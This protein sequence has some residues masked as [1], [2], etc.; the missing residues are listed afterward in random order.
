M[1][2]AY[3]QLG[4]RFPSLDEQ[5]SLLMPLRP[6]D[7]A[8]EEPPTIADLPRACQRL[9]SLGAG[10][11]LCIT[12]LNALGGTAREVMAVFAELFRRGVIVETF[13]ESGELYELGA[14]RQELRLLD[15]LVKRP[16]GPIAEASGRGGVVRP[17]FQDDIAEIRRLARSGMTARQIGLIFRLSPNSVEDILFR[18]EAP[19]PQ[20]RQAVS[21]AW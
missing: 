10:D 16:D 14:S 20:P 19:A 12:T 21:G 3:V 9:D 6:D 1:R 7:Y 17:I 11:R 2:L 8:I 13:D 4:A 5:V 15:W 18:I